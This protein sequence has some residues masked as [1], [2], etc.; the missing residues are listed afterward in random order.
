MAKTAN[1]NPASRKVSPGTLC[2][3]LFMGPIRLSFDA[4]YRD[5]LLGRATGAFRWR[6]TAHQCDGSLKPVLPCATKSMGSYTLEACQYVSERTKLM[7]KLYY[8]PLACSLS[9]H[10]ALREASVPF[11]LVRLA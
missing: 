2:I 11:E 1:F 10:V 7:L 5:A 3:L 4:A 9:P 6:A 8:A